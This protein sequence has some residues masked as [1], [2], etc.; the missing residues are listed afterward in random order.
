MAMQWSD[1][2][3][4]G[5][6]EIDSQHKEL[7]NRVNNL[8][9]A[10]KEGKAKAHLGQVLQFLEDYVVTH[11]GTEEKYMTKYGYPSFDQHKSQH[12]AFVQDFSG[13][14]K[15]FESDGASSALVIRLQ[16]Q[17]CDWLVSHITKTD[18]SLGAFLKT[19]LDQPVGTR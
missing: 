13:L 6:S 5:V 18:K 9:E 3:S 4:V 2:L 16:R 19:K 8:L 1:D 12:V 14:K 15:E 7:I 10:M 17:V 11:F